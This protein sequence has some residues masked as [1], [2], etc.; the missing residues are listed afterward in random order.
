MRTCY[1]VKSELRKYSRAEHLTV[2][3]GEQ[4][5]RPARDELKIGGFYY[6]IVDLFG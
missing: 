5:L 6:V 3:Q 1:R 2:G 4:V